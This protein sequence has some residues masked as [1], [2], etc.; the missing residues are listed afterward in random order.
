MGP[1]H[2]GTLPST[3]SSSRGEQRAVRTHARTIPCLPCP[4]SK[5]AVLSRACNRHRRGAAVK[6][7]PGGHLAGIFQVGLWG[8]TA[9]FA[10]VPAASFDRGAAPQGV[11][12]SFSPPTRALQCWRGL[13]PIPFCPCARTTR[14]RLPLRHRERRRRRDRRHRH[15]RRRA[16]APAAPP[17][18]CWALFTRVCAGRSRGRIFA[19]FGLVRSF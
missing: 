3:T 14:R 16:A 2:P 19:Y 1:S 18:P 12:R 4:L 6:H 10:A 8:A 9:V 7:L 15:H 5:R 17:H 13:A 11:L